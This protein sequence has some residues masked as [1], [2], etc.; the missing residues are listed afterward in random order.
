MK[1]CTLA[2]A[3]AVVLASA[4]CGGGSGGS[5]GGP[6]L[7]IELSVSGSYEDGAVHVV[8]VERPDGE[9]VVERT[10]PSSRRASLDVEPGRYRL[11]SYQR[12]CPDAGCDK[13]GEPVDICGR[14]F[15]IAK[16]D[17]ATAHI[18]VTPEEGCSIEFS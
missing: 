17:D 2:A 5:G 14:Y 9:Q 7:A 11:L 4:A 8:R 18:E 1:R 6:S 3:L 13:P 10:L 16:D 12:P 15:T